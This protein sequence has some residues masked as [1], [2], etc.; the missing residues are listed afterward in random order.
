MQPLVATPT[1]PRIELGSPPTDPVESERSCAVPRNDPGSQAF[2]PKPRQVQWAVDRAV[3]GQLTE[4][5]PVNW[6]N[7]GNA[8]SY[9]A[10]GLFPRV[11]L[12]GGGTIPPQVVL[13]VL[14]QESNLWQASRYTAPGSTGNPLVGDFYGSRPEEDQAENVI[15]SIDFDDADCGYGVG[16][17][18]DGMRLAGTNARTKPRFRSRNRGR[19]HWTTR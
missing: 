16:Q 13:G 19:S 3:S 10:Q 11:P 1:V 14:A 5:R 12:A 8:S 7:L 2:Q 6:R 9:S 18:T 17:I 4:L 15:W